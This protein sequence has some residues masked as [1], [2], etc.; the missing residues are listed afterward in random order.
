VRFD[1]GFLCRGS[2][3][4]AIAKEDNL[5]GAVRVI[6]DDVQLKI[7]EQAVFF[8]PERARDLAVLLQEAATVAT[9]E[10]KAGEAAERVL[11]TERTS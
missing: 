11:S 3:C 1:K 2:T 10:T 5:H 7:F 6:G 9:D 4:N 8:S